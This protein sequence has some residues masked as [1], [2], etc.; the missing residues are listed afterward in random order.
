MESSKEYKEGTLIVAWNAHSGWQHAVMDSLHKWVSPQTYSCKLCELTYG[1][2][3]PRESWK[4]FLESLHREVQ[5]YHKDE[6]PAEAFGPI[7]PADFPFILEYRQEAWQVLL[8]PGELDQINT[9][10]ALLEVLRQKLEPS[11]GYS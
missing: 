6:F 4:T 1:A 9:L 3:G 7:L 5:F 8:R 10:E 11:A 2:V